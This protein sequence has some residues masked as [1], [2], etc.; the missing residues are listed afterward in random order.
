M[1]QWQEYQALQGDERWISATDRFYTEGGG[2]K[3]TQEF[4]ITHLIQAPIIGQHYRERNNRILRALDVGAG[5]GFWSECLRR[6]AYREVVG[7]DLT[8]K[9]IRHARTRHP[10]IRFEVA[11][12]QKGIDFG[13]TFDLILCRGLPVYC[14]HEDLTE[15]DIM[16]ATSNLIK[17]LGPGGSLL[18]IIYS[19][20][21][22]QWMPCN[23][24]ALQ[25]VFFNHTVDSYLAHFSRFP[26]VE[27]EW[28]RPRQQEP[29]HIYIQMARR[30][31]AVPAG[32]RECAPLPPGAQMGSV[33]H[34]E[35]DSLKL[36][37]IPQGYF[38]RTGE[39]CLFVSEIF[40][41][42]GLEHPTRPHSSGIYLGDDVR[43]NF[44][45]FLNGAGRLSIGD[46]TILGPYAA[47]HTANHALEAGRIRTDKWEIEAVEIGAD[48]WI[49][50]HACILPGVTLGHRV[51][52]GAGAVVT[53]SAPDGVILAG[54]PACVVKERS[55]VGA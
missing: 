16:N 26:E 52:V 45:C 30:G 22:Q 54:N 11:D 10:G 21:N 48:C 38:Q 9:T 20:Q 29:G 24:K 36:V 28:Y 17:T 2:F 49:G 37:P 23:N 44:G 27:I 7:F 41:Q 39:R 14:L 8:E 15:P 50:M 13:V 43:I 40:V 51:I 53:K 42:N 46:R 35:R 6:I 18:F 33:I 3:Y 5:D 1:N 32:K 25:E 47:I 19:N 55:Q 12:L 4:G 31:N 34:T